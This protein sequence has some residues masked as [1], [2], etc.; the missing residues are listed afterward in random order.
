M[1]QYNTVGILDAILEQKGPFGRNQ[2]NLD[3]VEVRNS[4]VFLSGP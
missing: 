2:R 1:T 3:K 4:D